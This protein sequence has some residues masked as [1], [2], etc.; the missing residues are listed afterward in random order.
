MPEQGFQ[1]FISDISEGASSSAN[2]DVILYVTIRKLLF[3]VFSTYFSIRAPRCQ[4]I[5]RCGVNTCVSRRQRES[6]DKTP[7]Y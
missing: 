5:Q 2:S 3:C 6:M 1:C 7:L 4:E